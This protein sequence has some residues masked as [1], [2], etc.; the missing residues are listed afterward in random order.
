MSPFQEHNNNN[1][2]NACHHDRME[3]TDVRNFICRRH[4]MEY[5]KTCTGTRE[6]NDF[7]TTRA[8]Q[9]IQRVEPLLLIL[10]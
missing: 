3:L 6:R 1:K 4:Q 10:D 7:Y 9:Q 2:K 8:Q 5:A